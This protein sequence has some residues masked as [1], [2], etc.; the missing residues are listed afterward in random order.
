M[1]DLLVGDA[2]VVLQ[3]V[4]VL[5]AGGL[6]ELLGDGLML[7]SSH[8]FVAPLSALPRIPEK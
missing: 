5:G 2:A 7:R 8:V 1:I 6:N 3:D 4:V